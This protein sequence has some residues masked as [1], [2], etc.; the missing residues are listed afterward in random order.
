M[1]KL[2]PAFG[3][4]EGAN[5]TGSS[6]ASRDTGS[7]GVLPSN[8]I[9]DEQLWCLEELENSEWVL[10]AHST[11]QQFLHEDYTHIFSPALKKLPLD[12]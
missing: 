11:A 12:L 4:R 6:D 1:L 2:T 9:S 10:R 5:E 7:D 8:R 3:G